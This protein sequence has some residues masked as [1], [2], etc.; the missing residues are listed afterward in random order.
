MISGLR[1]IILEKNLDSIVIEVTN[2]SYLVNLATPA[3]EELSKTDTGDEIYIYTYLAV[4]ENSLDLYGFLNKDD[5]DLFTLLLTISGVG[6]KSALN[7]LNSVD[8]KM[9][10]ESI[11]QN[12][13]K[14]L[15]KVSGIGKKTAEKILLGLKD[16]LGGVEIEGDNAV[17]F[18]ALVSLG[19]TER[20]IREALKKITIKGKDHQ[21]LIKEALKEL[22]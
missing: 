22:G 5:M 15:S 21:E 18:D 17:V 9:I 13:P 1:G 20:D 19:Y 3:I 7:I 12:D 11:S 2:V 16:K 14:Y 4:R 6:P 8:K 10:E